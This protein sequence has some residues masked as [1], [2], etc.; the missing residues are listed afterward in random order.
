MPPFTTLSRRRALV[1]ALAVIALAG[2]AKPRV[3]GEGSRDPNK[4]YVLFQAS[5][6]FSN[7]L[8]SIKSNGFEMNAPILVF[9]P[10]AGARLLEV[11]P[12]TYSVGGISRGMGVGLT[13]SSSFTVARGRV[14]YIGDHRL[15]MHDRD[16]IRWEMASDLPGALKELPAPAAAEITGLPVDIQLAQ[17]P[18]QV[19]PQ[20]SL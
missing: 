15:S 12:G 1:A 18:A 5:S 19:K 20:G 11:N 13:G 6:S 9:V 8:I 3:A 10:P 16:V 7:A 14:T 17:P 4:G 2:C